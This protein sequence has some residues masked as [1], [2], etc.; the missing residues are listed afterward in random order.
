M[1]YLSNSAEVASW[2]SP[3]VTVA[4]VLIAIGVALRFAI[5]RGRTRRVRARVLLRALLPAR[6]VS[7]ASGRA[8][9]G[10]FLFNSFVF[11]AAF[12]WAVWS[13]GWY[14][15]QLSA[16]FATWLGPGPLLP[17]PAWAA[18]LVMII[19]LF[20]A[21]E[22]AYWLNHCLSHRVGWMWEFHKVHHTAESLSPLTNYR[23]HPVDTI[24]FYNM[25]AAVGG[26]AMAIVKLLL[27]EATSGYFPFALN[28]LI[29]LVTGLFVHLQHTHLW[30]SFPGRAGRWLLSPAHHQIHHSVHAHHHGRNFGSTLA[31]FDRL[32]GT[33]HVPTAKRE[34]LR[35]GVDGIGYDP[36]S[37][38]GSTIL[39]FADTA[40]RFLPD[41]DPVQA[42]AVAPIAR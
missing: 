30:I 4:T 25:A 2:A 14:S 33:L 35:F 12:G 17:A 16:V 31:I 3:A 27:G 7:S 1:D 10:W 9:I 5:P 19:A 23:V 22:F 21:Y 37:I 18:T 41:G 38:Q 15:S 20:V 29:F 42:P 34:K 11:S 39:P 28:A 36:H 13:G 32:F 6:I 24:I 40:R 8:D 26:V